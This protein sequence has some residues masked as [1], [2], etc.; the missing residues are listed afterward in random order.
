MTPPRAAFLAFGVLLFT[1]SFGWAARCQLDEPITFLSS[2]DPVY[3][4]LENEQRRAYE[5]FHRESG[6]LPF[7][8]PAIYL[9]KPDY[10][11]RWADLV[12][13]AESVFCPR[14][15]ANC[16]AYSKGVLLVILLELGVVHE[17]LAGDMDISEVECKPL[18]TKWQDYIQ[19]SRVESIKFLLALRRGRIYAADIIR[20]RIGTM[21]TGKVNANAYLAS[22]PGSYVVIINHELFPFVERVAELLLASMSISETGGGLAVAHD[23]EQIRQRL[24]GDRAILS[25]FANAVASMLKVSHVEADSVPLEG[26][27]RKLA[28]ALSSAVTRWVVA[29]E[30]IH[31][32]KDHVGA[33]SKGQNLVVQGQQTSVFTLSQKQEIEADINGQLLAVSLV[34]GA[35]KD[36]D[37]MAI[38]TAGAVLYLLMDH[39]LRAFG[40]KLKLPSS[41]DS[42]HPDPLVRL[43]AIRQTNE[44]IS[45][46]YKFNA[47][48]WPNIISETHAVLS[49]L[50]FPFIESIVIDGAIK[51][52]AAEFCAKL[53][54][55]DGVD[56]RCRD[57]RESIKLS[58]LEF[59]SLVTEANDQRCKGP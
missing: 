11:M 14:G 3:A 16:D 27:Y 49:E 59:C 23:R 54:K 34:S 22:G 12:S 58:R 43:E 45:S 35:G 8:L 44:A 51:I 36:R 50:A 6:R 42:A 39:Q 40:S 52:P 37:I 20:L 17:A 10:V 53:A 31:V 9:E 47:A 2:R 32:M 48:T 21:P 30:A 55:M 28:A 46:R 56:S 25:G 7:G 38:S 29:H 19:Y 13:D 4:W 5:K 18:P 15:L 26:P 57:S 24:A 33:L 41:P 1:C